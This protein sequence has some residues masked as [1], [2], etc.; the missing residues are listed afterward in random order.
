MKL[1][2]LAVSA[3]LATALV[4]TTAS[5]GQYGGSNGPGTGT[6]IGTN[7]QDADGDGIPNHLD[8]DYV[9]PGDGSGRKLGWAS[10]AVLTPFGVVNCPLPLQQRIRAGIRA[11][12]FGPADGSCTPYAPKDGTGFGRR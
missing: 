4:V 7:M 1:S 8:P 10:T 12:G 5:A 3:L 11:T 2:I 6:G 9:A